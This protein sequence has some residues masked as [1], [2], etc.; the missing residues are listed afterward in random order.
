[1]QYYE[2]F[3]I[4]GESGTSPQ[5]SGENPGFWESLR[6]IRSTPFST[7]EEGNISIP[8][9]IPEM[10]KMGETVERVE[11]YQADLKQWVDDSYTA[12]QNNYDENPENQLPVPAPPSTPVIDIT[13]ASPLV[14]LAGLMLNLNVTL[15]V[16]NLKNQIDLL[17]GK[18]FKELVD[19]LKDLQ[20][21]G[22]END[23]GGAKINLWNKLIDVR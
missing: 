12:M 23:I 14:Q 1:M 20:W 16:Q 13:N 19:A 7:D 8:V 6:G 3:L 4:H 21:N 18:Q 22:I 2:M 10:I 17:N 9:S 11:A 5:Q 15:N